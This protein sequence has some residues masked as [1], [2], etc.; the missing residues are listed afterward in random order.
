VVADVPAA[1]RTLLGDRLATLLEENDAAFMESRLLREVASVRVRRAALQ[2]FGPG[3]HSRRL[4][5]L[6][7]HYVPPLPTISVLLVSMRP[8]FLADAL[9]QIS[10]QTWPNIE[11]VLGLH[12]DH[13]TAQEI[14][15]ALAAS[16]HPVTV[17][18]IPDEAPFGEAL[19]RA[20]VAC[21]GTLLAKWDDDD[22]YGRDHL[23]DLA[24]AL[25]YSGAAL[26]AKAAEYVLL[27]D[28]DA[29]A[30][31]TAHW[32]ERRTAWVAGGTFLL[33]RQLLE[34]LGGWRP[35]PHAVDHALIR[36]ILGEGGTVYRTHGL[37][38]LLR[39]H[40]LGHTWD[41]GLGH[42]LRSPSQQW[43]LTPELRRVVLDTDL[44]SLEP[45]SILA[46]P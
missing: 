28:L 34:E 22:L 36:Q 3:A 14:D 10:R 40:A 26:A 30:R 29:V 15:T 8:A 18:R 39:R 32:S 2:E 23:W 6:A 1:V 17:V 44:L 19:N 38:Y 7:G 42:F 21:S 20:S 11:V 12:G 46:R 43:R 35:V 41:P 37:G 24:L 9:T 5:A 4:A 13:F 45:A 25:D 16:E 31:S 33:R 27:E